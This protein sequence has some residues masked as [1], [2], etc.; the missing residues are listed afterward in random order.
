MIYQDNS[1]GYAR[2]AHN[3]AF[4]DLARSHPEVASE[5][6]ILPVWSCKALQNR[7]YVF[8]VPQAG[9]LYEI[10]Y[11]GDKDELYFDA[12]KKWENICYSAPPT[13]L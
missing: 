7:K 12:Y 3:I 11:N 13:D 4:A 5:A 2:L 10:T 8:G 9:I 1:D 6:P